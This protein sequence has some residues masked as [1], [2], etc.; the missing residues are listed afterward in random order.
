MIIEV[1]ITNA[2]EIETQPD[3]S[4]VDTID[5]YAGWQLQFPDCFQMNDIN[6]SKDIL[7]KKILQIF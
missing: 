1:D 2:F 4:T 6:W 5:S 3:G 7:V